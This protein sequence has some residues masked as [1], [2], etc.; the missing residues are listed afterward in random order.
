MIELLQSSSLVE[1]GRPKRVLTL[2][3]TLQQKGSKLNMQTMQVV[4]DIRN[5]KSPGSVLWLQLI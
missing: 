5:A 4:Q 3:N 2:R 1:E